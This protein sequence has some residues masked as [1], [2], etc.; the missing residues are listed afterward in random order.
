[1]SVSVTNNW[2]E[3]S[4]SKGV[5]A[6][7]SF[8]VSGV[9][10]LVDALTAAG[11]PYGAV[12]QY[13]NSY[14]ED[15]TI[16]AAVPVGK[17]LVPGTLFR[18]EVDYAPLGLTLGIAP[19]NPLDAPPKF[20]WADEEESEAVDVDLF[21]NPLITS[22]GD[23]IDPPPELILTTKILRVTH[24]V[25]TIDLAMIKNF[26]WKTNDDPV[27]IPLCSGAVDEGCLLC[28]SIIPLGEYDEDAK[29]IQLQ[30]LFALRFF[31]WRW[32]FLDHGTR[33]WYTDTD[34]KKKI[35]EFFTKLGTQVSR[36]VRLNGKGKPYDA[37]SVIIEKSAKT[38]IEIG[39]PT[40]AEIEDTGKAVFLKWFRFDGASFSGLP[41]GL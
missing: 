37:D 20:S 10:R 7:L 11:P 19:P 36:P 6:H 8:D 25:E 24:W 22:N 28:R 29:M 39:K 13:R 15:P 3:T 27:Q 32:R 38:P 30:G 2:S 17:I 9:P 4:H 33:G 23:A 5:S 34:N 26:E 16:F 14:P 40:G 41:F 31:G 12:P 35:G 1:M 18:V 21:G